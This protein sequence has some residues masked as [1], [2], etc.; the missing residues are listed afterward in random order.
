[1]TRQ[2]DRA[3]G[4]IHA[5]ALVVGETGILVT[6]P[7]GSGKSRLAMELLQ[8]AR[9]AGRFAAL[10]ADDQVFLRAVGGRVL[11]V[12]PETISGL[13]E[14]R[15]SGILRVPVLQRAVMH[16]AIAVSPQDHAPRLPPADDRYEPGGGLSIP[17]VHAVAGQLRNPLELVD[18]FTDGRMLG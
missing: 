11:A 14:L 6:G 2:D 1:M 18:A 9:V 4:N 17:M 7:S 3:A 8:S 15:G 5:T 16:L 12:A 13:I 10:V